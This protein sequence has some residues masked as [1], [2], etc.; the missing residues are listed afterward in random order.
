VISPS[1]IHERLIF[2]YQAC[3][4]GQIGRILPEPDIFTTPNYQ[5]QKINALLV[6]TFSQLS[7]SKTYPRHQDS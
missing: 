7:V 1:K 3:H 2:H 6:H 5:A 4:T